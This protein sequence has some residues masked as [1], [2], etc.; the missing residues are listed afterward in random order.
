M[1]GLPTYDFSDAGV[2]EALEALG[3]TPNAVASTLS[4]MGFRG[5]KSNERNC[6]I[7][8]YIVSSIPEA[9]TAGVWTDD[10]GDAIVQAERGY[11]DSLVIVGAHSET[12]GVFVRCF[13]RG[14]YPDLIDEEATHVG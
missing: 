8:N 13:D 12:V 10:D 4:A 5:C 14:D 9:D 1:S 2:E 11:G 3:T 6:P 7:V